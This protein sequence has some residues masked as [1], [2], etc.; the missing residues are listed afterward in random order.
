MAE[1]ERSLPL[2]TAALPDNSTA[3]QVAKV[4]SLLTEV[5][6]WRLLVQ[7]SLHTTT[8]SAAKAAQLAKCR[9]SG[10]VDNGTKGRA[11]LAA[12]LHSNGTDLLNGLAS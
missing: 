4:S 6:R 7:A 2:N 11:S 9:C 5:C 8:V 1:I 12:V 10:T 3:S